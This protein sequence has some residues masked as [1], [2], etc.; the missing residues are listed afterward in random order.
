VIGLALTLDEM[1]PNLTN[2]VIGTIMGASLIHEFIG[3]LMAKTALKK[4]GEIPD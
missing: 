2:A 3:P 4:A 1:D